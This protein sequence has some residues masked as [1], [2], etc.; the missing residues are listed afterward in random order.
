MEPET[1]PL[2]KESFPIHHF[3][4]SMLAFRGVAYA[5]PNYDL[6]MLILLGDTFEVSSDIIFQ[7]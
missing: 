7:A 4:G 3:W 1:V 2:K 5:K 6:F